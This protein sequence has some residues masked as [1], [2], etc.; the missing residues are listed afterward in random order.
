MRAVAGFCVTVLRSVPES[1][2]DWGRTDSGELFALRERR[3]LVFSND[4]CE[5]RFMICIETY[6]EAQ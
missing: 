5:P 2:D 6:V 4:V 3:A 1:D